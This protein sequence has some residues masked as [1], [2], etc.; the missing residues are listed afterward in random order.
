M[1]RGRDARRLAEEKQAQRHRRRR[2]DDGTPPKPGP[3]TQDL[4][5]GPEVRLLQ[6]SRAG[7]LLESDSRLC[8]GSHICL[9]LNAGDATFLLK[10]RVLRSRASAP[11]GGTERYESAVAFEDDFVLCQEEVP[12]P[13]RA[14]PARGSRMRRVAKPSVAYLPSSFVPP[15]GGFSLPPAILSEAVPSGQSATDL[16]NILGIVQATPPQS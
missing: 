4:V 12:K 9:R 16:R 5:A 13:R 14:R 15:A 11:E 7:A 8:T 6:I 10:G 3:Q 1:R 2:L